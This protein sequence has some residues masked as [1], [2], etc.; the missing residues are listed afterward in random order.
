[1]AKTKKEHGNGVYVPHMLEVWSSN[2]G[3]A[4]KP[5]LTQYCKRFVIASTSM[6][7]AALH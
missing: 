6:Q 1:M 2:P 5:K 7:V 3:P 4:N